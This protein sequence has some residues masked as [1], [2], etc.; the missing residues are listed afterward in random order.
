MSSTRPRPNPRRGRVP[1]PGRPRCTSACCWRRASAGVSR[2]PAVA[3]E[4]PGGSSARSRG[5]RARLATP[6]PAAVLSSAGDRAGRHARQSRTPPRCGRRSGV[7]HLS[8]FTSGCRAPCLQSVGPLGRALPSVTCDEQLGQRRDQGALSQEEFDAEKAGALP[9]TASSSPT[10]GQPLLRRSRPRL[11]RRSGTP[12]R[13]S[14]RRL[15]RSSD[16]YRAPETSSRTCKARSPALNVRSPALS[17]KGSSPGIRSKRPLI[18]VIHEC[19][20]R[21]CGSCCFGLVR[22]VRGRSPG[23]ARRVLL[24]RLSVRGGLSAGGSGQGGAA[25]ECCGEDCCPGPGSVEAEPESSP[26][27]GQAG[28]GV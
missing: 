7:S 25:V 1:G 20:G 8:R 11:N 10:G 27:A 6:P 21:C 3:G 12:R 23:L 22:P 5:R 19:S 14:G 9:S 24:L 2:R 15:Y 28:G 26:A 18:P 4:R 17:Y 13:P 16:R